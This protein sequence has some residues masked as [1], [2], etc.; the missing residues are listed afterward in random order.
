MA[1]EASDTEML[2]EAYREARTQI[3]QYPNQLERDIGLA[4]LRLE[5]S[6]AYR[7]LVTTAV[8]LTDA[9]AA[10]L[11]E[12]VANLTGGEAVSSSIDALDRSAESFAKK[13]M[14]DLMAT[15]ALAQTVG[16][17][18][19]LGNLL[20][21]AALIGDAAGAFLFGLLVAGG[22][23]VMFLLRGGQ[24]AGEALG[25]AWN[26]SWTW[27][28]GLGAASDKALE[29]ARRAQAAVLARARAAALPIPRFTDR[30]RTRA[31][32]VIG[33]AWAA[34]GI[35]AV[36]IALG[37]VKAATDWWDENPNN[38]KNTQEQIDILTK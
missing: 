30:V 31:K 37:A 19:T 22:S 17:I 38:P 26:S 2:R 13:V 34:V 4:A 23:G 21:L 27:A 10:P 7:E 3:S 35:A 29:P 8:G 1:T 6:Q 18:A 36:L 25:S 32:A 14:R 16:L 5:A 9:Q 15:L 28:N 24:V 33:F 11:K 12:Y 20:L